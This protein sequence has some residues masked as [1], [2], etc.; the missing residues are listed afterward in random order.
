MDDAMR[1][2]IITSVAGTVMGML[3]GHS[4][5]GHVPAGI[6]GE[7]AWLQIARPL[8][9]PAGRSELSRP[10]QDRVSRSQAGPTLSQAEVLRLAKVEAKKELGKRFNDYEIKSVI[11]EPTTGLWSV[12]FDHNPPHRSPDGCLVLFVRDKD[13]TTEL[14]HCK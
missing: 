9:V 13:K 8:D 3:L 14:Q 2:F 10:E 1:F 12:T 7:R 4:F 5:G 6:A 11:F